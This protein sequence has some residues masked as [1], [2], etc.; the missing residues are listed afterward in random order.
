[1]EEANFEALSGYESIRIIIMP[2][3]NG[4]AHHRW[5]TRVSIIDSA[6]Y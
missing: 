4:I 1:M 2:V 5:N 6:R 3:M